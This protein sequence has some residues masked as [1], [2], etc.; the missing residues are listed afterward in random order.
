MVISELRDSCFC[1]DYGNITITEL[2]G[3]LKM[4]LSIEGVVI[5]EEIYAPD[6][7][8][9]VIIRGLGKV[10]RTYFNFPQI[11]S[12]STIELPM[13]LS[14][15]LSFTSAGQTINKSQIVFYSRCSTHYTNGLSQYGFITR[16]QDK[17]TS[18]S[19]NEFIQ[20]YANGQIIYIG[21]TYLHDN[22]TQYYEAQW[23]TAGNN[24]NA[25][26]QNVSVGTI[27]DLLRQWKGISIS[28]NE[29]CYY[30]IFAEYNGERV[31]EIRFINDNRNF[32]QETHLVY[33]NALGF[34]ETLT[35]T[36]KLKHSTELGGTF[37][38]IADEYK[39]ID[40]QPVTSFELNSGHINKTV[41][42]AIYD[43]I[44]SDAIY[45]YSKGE[46]IQ[47][48]V[49]TEE[50]MEYEQ[51]SNR[52]ISIT[53]TMRPAY[54]ENRMFDEEIIDRPIR[55]FDYTFDYTFN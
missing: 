2:A 16:Y 27:I 12:L 51:P 48:M 30:E 23:I 46:I 9:R 34:L 15:D 49:I 11:N 6:Y 53:L 47:K 41:A 5:L 55:V 29:L 19:R 42:E 25:I 20:Y 52:P 22:A 21:I 18:S 14:V 36:G 28:T 54:T 38:T 35:L 37:A 24:Y 26:S 43:I 17:K 33:F 13:A 8:G 31:D 40:T 44:S 45:T 50:N 1:S 10:I 39:K 7:N 3:E 4:Y 32:P